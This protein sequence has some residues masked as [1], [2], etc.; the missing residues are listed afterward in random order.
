MTS[1]KTYTKQEVDSLIVK[2]EEKATDITVYRGTF[3]NRDKVK[4]GSV[5]IEKSPRATL[6]YSSSTGVGIC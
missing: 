3:P 6:T 2:Q 5:D 1:L 4:E